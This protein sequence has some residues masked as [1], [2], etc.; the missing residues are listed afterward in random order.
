VNGKDDIAEYVKL[1]TEIQGDPPTAPFHWREWDEDEKA[2]KITKKVRSLAHAHFA[3]YE[4]IP[5]PS[6]LDPS[7]LP[8][9]ALILAMQAVSFAAAFTSVLHTCLLISILFPG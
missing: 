2:E 7:E 9:G 4:D 1:F 3:E 8:G 5:D 6:D